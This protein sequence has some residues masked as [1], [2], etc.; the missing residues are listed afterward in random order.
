MNRSYSILTLMVALAL[1]GTLQ[2]A[3][4]QV[5][6]RISYQGLVLDQNQAT[7][8]D[9]TY[10]VTFRLYTEEDGVGAVGSPSP[11]IAP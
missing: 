6:N 11:S 10:A 8:A 4:A 2:S 7:L 1:A 9:G 5:P 3:L